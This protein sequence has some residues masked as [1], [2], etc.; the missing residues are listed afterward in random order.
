MGMAP[1][2]PRR[3]GQ[4]G[5]P[6]SMVLLYLI[7]VYRIRDGLILI[8]TVGIPLLLSFAQVLTQFWVCTNVIY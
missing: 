3:R 8:G 1:D 2:R 4:G 6:L 7:G 5:D